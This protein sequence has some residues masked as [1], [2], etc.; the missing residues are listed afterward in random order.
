MDENRTL[1][2]IEAHEAGKT[3]MVRKPYRLLRQHERKRCVAGTASLNLVFSVLR[4]SGSIIF[5]DEK[6]FVLDIRVLK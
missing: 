1:R 5:N 3:F 2:F 4:I 6:K